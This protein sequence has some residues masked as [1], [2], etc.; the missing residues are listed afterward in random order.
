MAPCN[1][2]VAISLTLLV[3]V[4]VAVGVGVGLYLK[5][6]ND[7]GNGN[8][9]YVTPPVAA[10]CPISL[11]GTGNIGAGYEF[12][13]QT[14]LNPQDIISRFFS[15]GP[16]NLFGILQGVDDRVADINSRWNQFSGCSGNAP[17]A[18]SLGTDAWSDAPTFYAQ[19]SEY[20]S[21]GN[22]FDQFGQV[23]DTTY[24]YVR[25][26]DGI[27]AAQIVGNGTFGNTQS[28]TIWF[29][30]GIINRNGSHCVGMVFAN[31]SLPIFEMSVAGAG[32]GFCGVQMKSNGAVLNVTGSADMGTCDATD[33]SC[34]SASSITTPATCSLAVDT[35]YLPAL[36]RKA[37]TDNV[38]FGAS[39]YP[40]GELDTVTLHMTGNDDTFF[41]PSIPTV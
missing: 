4:G 10:A 26:G 30:V 36:G 31:P 27:V 28:V 38:N 5:N 40:G 24:L 37:Y 33:S 20:W 12:R 25:G 35:F 8:I 11:K 2:T 7:G 21:G 3:V 6:K 39:A 32:I 16:T 22:G 1:K 15:A 34:T 13:T 19:C 9:P 41:G 18:Y 14:P 17:T 23:N 29:S